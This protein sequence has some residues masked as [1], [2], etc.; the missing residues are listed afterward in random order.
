MQRCDDFLPID[1]NCYRLMT[2]GTIAAVAAAAAVG[3]VAVLTS[4]RIDW[5][6]FPVEV[7]SAP[8]I[9]ATDFVG[10][11]PA[12]ASASVHWKFEYFGL[13]ANFSFRLW[14]CWKHFGLDSVAVGW[15]LSS[16]IRIH[17]IPCFNGLFFRFISKNPSRQLPLNQPDCCP[18]LKKHCDHY[19]VKWNRSTCHFRKRIDCYPMLSGCWCL[20]KDVMRWKTVIKTKTKHENRH[21]PKLQRSSRWSWKGCRWYRGWKWREAVRIKTSLKLFH[22]SVLVGTVKL[23]RKWLCLNYRKWNMGWVKLNCWN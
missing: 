10:L 2:T 20:C 23:Q 13:F 6:D 4:F 5:I 15:G 11:F 19:Q 1:P 7:D 12:V 17:G 9:A 3:I 18:C 14:C 16:S 22:W 21:S 8:K